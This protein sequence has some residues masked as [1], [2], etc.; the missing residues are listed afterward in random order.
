[1][2]VLRRAPTHCP[3]ERA[4]HVIGGRWKTMLVFHLLPGPSRYADLRRQLPDCAERVLV[5]QLRE[6]ESDRVIERRALDDA[7]RQVEYRLTAL[8]RELHELFAVMRRW[9]ERHQAGAE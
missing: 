7:Q 2:T 5:R 4:V 6:L 3:I 8:G 9:G 1:M